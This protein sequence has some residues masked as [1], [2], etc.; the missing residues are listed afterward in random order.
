MRAAAP[1]RKGRRAHPNSCHRSRLC[2]FRETGKVVSVDQSGIRYPVVVRFE[3]VRRRC[4]LGMAATLAAGS[5]P[6]P[7]V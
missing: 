5:A 2:R 3:K 7:C 4:E 6:Q 1:A